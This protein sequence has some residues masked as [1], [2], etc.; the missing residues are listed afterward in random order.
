LQLDALRFERIHAVNKFEMRP[1]CKRGREG[2]KYILVTD[3][4]ENEMGLQAG[5][6]KRE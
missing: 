2:L 4:D 3:E 5:R 6:L 1:R